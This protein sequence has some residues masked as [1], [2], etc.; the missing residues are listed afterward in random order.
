MPIRRPTAP[1]TKTARIHKSVRIT[2][3]PGKKPP[4]MYDED[5]DS[6]D[7]PDTALGGAKD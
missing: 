2:Q 4:R 5:E 1:T 3:R 7:V 6:F